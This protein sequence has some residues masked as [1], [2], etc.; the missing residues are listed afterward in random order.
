MNRALIAVLIVAP[1]LALSGAERSTTPPF[2]AE[3]EPYPIHPSAVQSTV[4]E[5]HA[6]TVTSANQVSS[7]ITACR[8]QVIAMYRALGIDPSLDRYAQRKFLPKRWSPRTP[9]PLSGEFL[10][11]FSIDCP[12]YHP[13]PATS[14]RVALP[15][16][17]IDS[18][19]VATVGKG[20]DGWGIGVAVSTVKDPLRTVVQTWDKDVPAANDRRIQLHLR[21]DLEQFIPTNT[22]D[23][24][25]SMIDAATLTS[26]NTWHFGRHGE[27]YT[28]WRVYGPHPLGSLGI[29]EGTNAAQLSDLVGLLRAGEAT[30][31]KPIPHALFGPAK[32]FWKAIV[33]PAINWDEWAGKSDG[34]TGAVPYGGVIQLDPALDLSTLRL[35]LPARRILEAI[36]RYGW[37]LHD[38]GVRDMD[39]WSS[40]SGDE[41]GRC[42]QEILTVL[43]Q[44][45]LY[46]VPAPA[47]YDA[48]YPLK[49]PRDTNRRPAST[50]DD[51]ERTA[52]TKTAPVGTRTVDPTILAQWDARLFDAIRVQVAAG[53]PALYHSALFGSDGAITQVDATGALV[54]KSQGGEITWQWERVSRSDRRSLATRLRVVTPADHALIAFHLLE[55]GDRSGAQRHLDLAGAEALTVQELFKAP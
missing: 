12:L 36:Q 8:K 25:L 10:Q 53:F 31:D 16:G 6:R 54:L 29:G 39:V 50:D 14:P 19:H 35:S 33:Y 40:A 7:E 21:A 20:G 28:G 17:Y 4:D 55:A 13:I 5:I 45:T 42:D 22:G 38:T 51:D 27:V 30:S 46:V 23:R 11:P 9:Q 52:S 44:A 26:T 15:R 37:Y 24:H 18:F 3:L 1:L 49:T 41:L 34:G 32:K 43:R 48:P 47:K 2:S